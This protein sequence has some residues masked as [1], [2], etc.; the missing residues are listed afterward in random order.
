[1]KEATF[2]T[3]LSMLVN[4]TLDALVQQEKPSTKSHPGKE[5]PSDKRNRPDRKEFSYYQKVM[6]HD[7]LQIVGHLA[8]ISTG[9]FKMD[10][11]KPLPVNRDF[12]FRLSLTSEVADKPSMVFVARS[13]WCKVD[14]LDPNIYN[15]GFQ[16]IQIAPGD[17]EIFNRMMEKYGR[18]QA[19]RSL[20]LRHSNKW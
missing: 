16:L 2:S 8:D 10:S 17:L 19:K 20:N 3:R 11:Q 9:G 12:R 13:R 6:D 14:P 1:M 7:T 15:V 4:N 5:L 18:D